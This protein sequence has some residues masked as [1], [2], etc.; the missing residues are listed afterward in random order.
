MAL[1]NDGRV[2]EFVAELKGNSGGQNY[3]LPADFDPAKF[4][5]V[6]IHCKAFAYSFGVANLVA[7]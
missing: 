2:V 6:I 3:K 5:Q 7:Q 4:N 1:G